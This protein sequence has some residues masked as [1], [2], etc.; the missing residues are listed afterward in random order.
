MKTTIVMPVSRPDFLKRIFAQLDLMPI[1]SP[2]TNILTYIDGDL[3]LFE[4]ARNLTVASKFAEKLCIFRRKG[5]PNVGS[6]KRRRQRIA[7]IHNEMKQFITSDG[8]D[9]IFSLEDDTLITTNTFERLHKLYSLYPHAGFI[10]GI[11]I[12]RW[13]Y[14]MI[15]AWRTD[16]IYDPKKL[17]TTPLEEGVQEVDAAGLYGCL[18]PKNLYLSHDFKPFNDMLGPDVDFGMQL[19]KAGYKNYVD[20]DLKYKHL[21]KRGELS[22]LKET[23][24]QVEQELQ[25]DGKWSQGVK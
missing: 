15:G 9:F 11:E 18:I 6:V 4:L 12:G 21:T 25:S 22:F 8:S 13:G 19:R 10:S 5:L 20:N 24:I 2:N 14:S 16:D 17:W 1:D 23:I 7:D 3:E